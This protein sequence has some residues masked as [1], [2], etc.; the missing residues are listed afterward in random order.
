MGAHFPAVELDNVIRFSILPKMSGFL[1]YSSKWACRF[2]RFLQYT[3]ELE[4]C[5]LDTDINRD[6]YAPTAPYHEPLSKVAAT[7]R[8]EIRELF[9]CILKIDT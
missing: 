4:A 6:Y 1:W 8:G 5:S 7:F 3:S 9:G 2:S